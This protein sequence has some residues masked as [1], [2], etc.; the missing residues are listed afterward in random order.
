[1]SKKFVTQ[2]LVETRV[3]NDQRRL[4]L[5]LADTRGVRQIL[6][7]P[8]SLATDLASVLLSSAK[9]SDAV[10]A[11]L[12][13]VPSTFFVG[14]ATHQ[15]LVLVKFDDDPPYALNLDDARMLSRQ[16]LDESETAAR[17]KVPA[18]Q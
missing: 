3:S 2:S 4:E 7:L 6:S 10:G 14:H 9:N 11:R 5:T 12:T 15:R 13:K 8:M 18:L 1:M 16:M 17:S